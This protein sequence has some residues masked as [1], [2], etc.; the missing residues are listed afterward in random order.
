MVPFS[1]R[2]AY[3][4]YGVAVLAVAL[5]L[6]ARSFFQ[7]ATADRAPFFFFYA[8]A[9]LS[10]WFGGWGPGL[11]ATA[12]A[13]TAGTWLYVTRESGPLAARH[14]IVP[15]VFVAL[16]ALMVRIV[17]GM[18][19]V[20]RRL[21]EAAAA[22]RRANDELAAANERLRQS[23]EDLQRFAYATSH[24][25]QEPLRM[26]GIYSELL[27]RENAGRLTADSAEFAGYI[28]TSVHRMHALIDDILAYSRVTSGESAP[29][30]SVSTPSA[31]GAA[32]RSLEAAIRD[33]Q[34]RVTC[35]ELPNIMADEKRLS[36]VF[37][38]LISNA[39]KYRGEAIPEVHVSAEADGGWCTFSVKDNGIGIDPKYHEQIFAL[40]QRL[41][42]NDEYA[43]TGIG[44]AITKRI[45]DQWGGRIWVESEPGRGSTFRFTALS[46]DAP[47]TS[48]TA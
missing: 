43:G 24:D 40:F 37:Q 22:Q 33:S 5:A 39:I 7:S 48:V 17:A 38:N 27:L 41:H 36:L 2:S 45:V 46:G 31:L 3:A 14:L 9:V 21:R 19:A 44:L 34:A 30:R 25:L 29:L 18:H 23:N 8:A 26:V 47:A 15:V 35:D 20:N 11:L 6:V 12:L 32:L 16:C 28:Q 4:R 13:C 1:D 42:T 10:A